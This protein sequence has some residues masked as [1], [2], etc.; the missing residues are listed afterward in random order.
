MVLVLFIILIAGCVANDL[1]TEET[2]NPSVS[3]QNTANQTE[4]NAAINQSN[5]SK[6]T[7]EYEI[8]Y[9]L[10]NKRYDG[11]K[12]YYVLIDPIDLNDKDFKDAIKFLV[13][14]MIDKYGTK[15][16]IEIHDNIDSLNI[17]YKEYGDLSLNR[18]TTNQ[19]NE[20]MSLHHIAA[21]QGELETG[22]YLNTLSYFPSS[23]LGTEV[24]KYAETIEFKIKD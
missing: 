20:L 8:I 22:L 15:I 14:D 16:S 11:G 24:D 23:G 19:E 3:E 7:P 1:D 9:S 5:Q 12:N 18:P 13:I 2:T 10:S 6:Q 17:S 21:F 4:E